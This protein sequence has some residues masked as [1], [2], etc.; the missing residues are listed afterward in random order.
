MDWSMK[1]LLKE[2][3]LSATYRQSSK[4]SP[5]LIARDPGNHLYARGPRFRLSAEQV[6]DQALA[7]SGLLSSKMYGP[8]VMPWQPPGVW[9]TVYSGESWEQS[10]GED[11]YRRALYTFMKRTSP[12]P[13]FI[14][15]DATSREVC[16]V[17]R[18][19][20]NTPLQALVTLNDPVYLEASRHLAGK[21][22]K[23]GG[24]DAEAAIKAGYRQA[25]MRPV[26]EEKLAVLQRL[27]TRAYKKYQ[28]EPEEAR[29]LMAS[30]AA[31]S[32]HRAALT[33]VASAIMNLDEFLTKS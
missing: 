17:Q 6:R 8:S 32:P 5:E 29:K 25:M 24:G 26:P 7:V 16:L 13:S 11:Q 9:Q 15:F 4:A 3:V 33:I 30:D 19:R 2:I 1:A 21:M 18:I 10:Q 22:E 20:T 23:A 14:S 28:A 27:Y 31:V 12:Y